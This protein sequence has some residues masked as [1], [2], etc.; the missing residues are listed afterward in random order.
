ML[1]SQRTKPRCREFTGPTPHSVAL[2]A[3][4]PSVRPPDFLILDR[5]RQEEARNEVVAFTKYQSNCDMKMQWEKT[6]DR[7]IMHGTIER[8]VHE[9]MQQY[10]MRVEARR[11]SLRELLER[12][13]LD[14]IQEMES[15]GET[16]LERQAKMR[17]R[18]KF[19]RE[20][21][22]SERQKLVA[23][24]LDLQFRE[25]CE[26]LRAVMTRR[27]Q[28][29]VCSERMAQ[30]SLKEQV[31]RQKEEEDHLFA[32]LWERD[33]Q[34]KEEREGRDALQQRERNREMVDFLQVQMAAAEEQRLQAKLLKE[35]EAQLLREQREML[36]L[37]EERERQH[38]LQS[39]QQTRRL[40]D[41]SLRLKMKRLTRE[42]QEELA[43]DMKI[44][45]QLLSEEQDESQDRQ[46]KKLQ[47]REEQR[48]YREY[49]AQ[50]L[51]EQ[52]RQEAEMDQLMEAELNRSWAKRAEQWRLEKEARNRLMREVMDTRR[53]QMQ[54]KLDENNQK[55]S[56]LAEER[57]Q[58][59]KA[60]EEHKALEEE[61]MSSK[62]KANQEY[63]GDLLA[64]VAYQQRLREAEKAEEWQEFEQGRTSEDKYQKKL[65]E[66][67]SCPCTNPEQVHPLRRVR[68]SSPKDWLPA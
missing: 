53:L 4:Q 17:E 7:R 31:R 19:L 63:Q 36:K 14:Y 13:E 29:E 23:E 38:K 65:Q 22:E 45:E 50:Q 34:A 16:T 5:R 37:E 11:E 56:Q 64:Q 62:K 3:R 6:T 25:Q 42:Q 57:E 54:A 58:L 12:E 61:K 26:E 67:L 49:L 41:H 2:R 9:T 32:H 44:M 28:D 18:A 48:R 47:L 20:K 35:E 21:R 27:R 39:Q 8:K 51:D 52:K 10:N 1:V 66:V 40:L 46:H 43:L 55:Q 15:K 24:K 59:A 30:L 60:I 33:R 68:I